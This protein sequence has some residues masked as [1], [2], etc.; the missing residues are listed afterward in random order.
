MRTRRRIPTC[1]H[2]RAHTH[3]HT[4]TEMQT[5]QI[6]ETR[7]GHTP[8][9]KIVVTLT[10]QLASQIIEPIFLIYVDLGWLRDLHFRYRGLL[11]VSL[12]ALGLT[13]GTTQGHQ[14]DHLGPP[15]RTFESRHRKHPKKPLLGDLFWDPNWMIFLVFF[16]LVFTS[17]RAKEMRSKCR[18]ICRKRIQK[19]HFL[20]IILKLRNCVSTA[21]ARADRGS[22][23]PET[24]NKLT[25]KD[26]R[27]KTPH[28]H[29]FLW[30]PTRKLVK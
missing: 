1:A 16:A 11:L 18:K 15:W 29:D 22:R 12:G 28:A 13:F 30:N 17:F 27:T 2:T 21:P 8:F 7:S 25:Q 23:L 20:T 10:K 9:N 5:Q 3:T 19:L 24:V 14:K 4:H 6:C 26:T